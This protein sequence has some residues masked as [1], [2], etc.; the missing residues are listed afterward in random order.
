MGLLMGMVS[1]SFSVILARPAPGG[2]YAAPK[3]SLD[4]VTEAVFTV[5]AAAPR[6]NSEI[7]V[8]TPQGDKTPPSDAWSGLSREPA[9]QRVSTLVVVQCR[10][11]FVW[12]GHDCLGVHGGQPCP[13]TW[14]VNVVSDERRWIAAWFGL[15]AGDI[16]VVRNLHSRRTELY[17]WND[18]LQ[19]RIDTGHSRV[20]PDEPDAGRSRASP[21]SRRYRVQLS[22]ASL[23]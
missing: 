14:L 6:E 19:T 3:P 18:R 21:K 22:A 1:I 2:R 8:I 16:I 9:P 10:G 23:A 13:G 11:L 12:A 7:R 15:S 17:S 4:R 20:L 5:V